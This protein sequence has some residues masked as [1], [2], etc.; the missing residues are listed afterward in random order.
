MIQKLNVSNFIYQII[1]TKVTHAF[2]NLYNLKFK[3]M[4]KSETIFF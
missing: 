2:I 1:Q 4:F 3:R